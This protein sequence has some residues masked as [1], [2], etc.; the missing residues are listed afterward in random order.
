VVRA[1]LRDAHRA[2]KQLDALYGDDG[3]NFVRVRAESVAAAMW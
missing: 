3:F 2:T 1:R